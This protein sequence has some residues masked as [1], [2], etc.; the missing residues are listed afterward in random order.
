MIVGC[1]RDA[2]LLMITTYIY[3]QL[4][5]RNKYYAPPP[6]LPSPLIVYKNKL[7]RHFSWA[8]KSYI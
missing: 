7:K 3:K 1:L 4:M 5:T 2:W 6:P 8:T